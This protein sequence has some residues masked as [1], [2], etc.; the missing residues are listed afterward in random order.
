MD[1][2]FSSGTNLLITILVARA[3]D[4]SAFGIF[5]LVYAAVTVF[6]GSIDGLVCEPFAVIHSRRPDGS[7]R[8]DLARASG[9]CLL[10]GG[11]GALVFAAVALPLPD[12]RGLLL[13][14][15][16]I[17]PALLLQSLWRF[18]SFALGRPQTAV[19]NDL[20]WAVVQVAALAIVLAGGWDTPVT[21]VLAWGGG[22][23]VAALVG[24][25]QLGVLPDVRRAVAWVRETAHLGVR[26][27]AEFL[28]T[29]GA[30]QAALSVTGSL[31]GLGAVA[32][33]RGAQVAYG[34]VTALANGVRVAGTPIAV[35]QQA[36][37]PTRL[38]LV[39]RAVGGGL[40]ALVGVW[41]VL[42]LL[43]PDRAG[44][45]LVGDSW[46]LAVDVLPAI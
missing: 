38:R 12:A 5:A 17:L 31:A 37:G 16:A 1:Q 21:L 20:V 15:A 19:V 39:V 41:T 44:D 13:A 14:Y 24:C 11:A 32:Q 27:A 30:S 42:L 33:L 22:A 36:R 9:A 23:A 26:Y 18:A 6:Q 29:F 45:A 34:P 10:L 2:A 25:R 40:A 8:T 7:S 3:A 46:A 35:R 43:L 28:G 4:V